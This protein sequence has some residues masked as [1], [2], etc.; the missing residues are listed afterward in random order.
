MLPTTHGLALEQTA[1]RLDPA[2]LLAERLLC[3]ALLCRWPRGSGFCVALR[4]LE[5]FAA[6]VPTPSLEIGSLDI[7]VVL[8]AHRVDDAERLVV[9]LKLAQQPRERVPRRDGWDAVELPCCDSRGDGRVDGEDERPRS[10]RVGLGEPDRGERELDVGVVWE[11]AERAFDEVV[12]PL[13][14]LWLKA[15]EKKVSVGAR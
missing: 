5:R 3:L 10:I 13:S 9:Q 11:D 8:V 12:A 14:C 1:Q 4:R 2:L 6:Q 15:G 7:H